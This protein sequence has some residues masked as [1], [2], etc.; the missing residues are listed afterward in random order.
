MANDTSI[1]WASAPLLARCLRRQLLRSLAAAA[2][3]ENTARTQL[4]EPVLVSVAIGARRTLPILPP[5]ASLYDRAR[6]YAR[7]L[8]MLLMQLAQPASLFLRRPRRCVWRH[9]QR[10]C[11]STCSVRSTSA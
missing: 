9:T 5:D 6:L 11:W 8:N 10:F 4:P 7:K 1:R 3:Q 2:P